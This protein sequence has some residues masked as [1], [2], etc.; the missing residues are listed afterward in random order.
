MLIESLSCCN[1]YFK[2]ALA[3]T[4]R[5]RRETQT[6][7]VGGDDDLGRGGG[8]NQILTPSFLPSFFPPPLLASFVCV[9]EGEVVNVFAFR[10]FSP[11]L[12]PL[13]SLPPLFSFS[14]PS[15]QHRGMRSPSTSI[16]PS[17]GLAQQLA[18]LAALMLRFASSVVRPLVHYYVRT[19]LF[20][21]NAGAALTSFSYPKSDVGKRRR[22]RAPDGDELPMLLPLPSSHLHPISSPSIK[23]TGEEE[24][25]E[26]HMCCS[27]V[28][29]AAV[30]A[31]AA[32]LE[33]TLWAPARPSSPRSA[34]RMGRR[35]RRHKIAKMNRTCRRSLREEGK[36]KKNEKPFSIS[37]FTHSSTRNLTYFFSRKDGATKPLAPRQRLLFLSLFELLNEVISTRFLFPSSLQ[38]RCVKNL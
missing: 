24:E 8:G 19:R 22:R 30:A 5:R 16:S 13:R 32:A 33:P 17:F 23:A 29:A 1:V 37:S 11:S 6:V 14:S 21:K 34:V 20:V 26:V 7:F 25:E 18:L 38:R 36:G 28:A 3:S 10:L 12:S 31:P 4:R 27:E 35:S 2:H 9:C 15:F